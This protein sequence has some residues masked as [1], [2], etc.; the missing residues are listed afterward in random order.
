MFGKL[1]GE[2]LLYPIIGDPI[3]FVKS[4]QRLTAEFEA[5]GHNG[6]C[7]PMQVPDGQLET[8]VR[9]LGRV[10]NVR[11][12]LITMP[13]KN[14][15]FSYC[16]TSSETAKL[17]GVVNIVRR[18][19]DG[20]WHGDMFDGLAFVAAQKKEGAT[21]R[22]ARVL[23]VGAGGAGRGSEGELL[24][25][26]VRELVLHDANQARLDDLVSILSSLGRGRVLAGPPD[27]T[28]CDIVV[29]ATPLGMSPNDPLPV[30]ANSL[31]ASMFVGDV[32][33][34]HGVTP[35]L[36]AAHAIGCKTADGVHM[37]DAGMHLM[38]DFLLGR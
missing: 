16:A 1:S 26:G 36:Q 21:L 29:N 25:E 27:P 37:V 13:H 19:P 34:G 20:S 6:I 33:A 35:L 31:S 17:L 18:N 8:V 4:P 14:T 9:G 22:G 11:G 5:R 23:Q 32:V 7:F 15:M 10:P 28:G 12:M 3:I 30:P 2:T 24:S 38:P